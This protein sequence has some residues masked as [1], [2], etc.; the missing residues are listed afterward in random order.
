MADITIL[1]D[2]VDNAN[3]LRDYL[4]DKG[5]NVH[6]V[7]CP[8]EFL[9]S[10][11]SQQRIDVLLLDIQLPGLDGFTILNRL[12]SE[13]PKLYDQ[14]CIIAVT[15]LAMHGDRER[16]IEAGADDYISKPFKLSEIL[17]LIN[18]WISE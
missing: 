2:H 11:D 8:I 10:V 12:R 3:I 16:C 4:S 13:H 1:D 17:K 5:H 7:Y 15:A 6:A 14:C 18:N 9:K